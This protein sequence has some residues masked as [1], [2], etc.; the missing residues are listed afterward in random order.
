MLHKNS[1]NKIRLDKEKTVPIHV[2]PI[3]GIII[4]V[5]LGLAGLAYLNSSLLFPEVCLIGVV[6]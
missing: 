6:F 4:L 2:L 5:T 1:I 3:L